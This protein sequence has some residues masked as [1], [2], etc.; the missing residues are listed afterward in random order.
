M[1]FVFLALFIL[2]NFKAYI[3]IFIVLRARKA[4]LLLNTKYN[5][6]GFMDALKIARS[7]GI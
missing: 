4:V 7:S 3:T 5:K 1:H 6:D 2:V